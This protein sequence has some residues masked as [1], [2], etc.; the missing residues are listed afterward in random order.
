MTEAPVL[1]P[2]SNH[3]AMLWRSLEKKVKGYGW[4]TLTGTLLAS[5][6]LAHPRLLGR[7]RFIV[8][9]SRRQIRAFHLIE[10]PVIAYL[11]FVSYYALRRVDRAKA[12]RFSV[13]VDT[14]NT[15]ALAFFAFESA[16][17]IA[18]FPHCV[19]QGD[20]RDLTRGALLSLVAAGVG[21]RVQLALNDYF[22]PALD[23]RFAHPQTEEELIQLVKRARA[24]GAQL[25]VRG[26]THC[27]HPAIFTDEG[28]QHINVQLDRY[29]RILEWNETEDGQRMRVTVQ[30]GCHL[31]V[32]PGDPLSNKENSLLYQLEEKGWALPDL[33]GI[34]HQTVG[35]FLS[36]GSMGGTTRHDLGRAIVG[37]RLI[38]GTGK[39]HD[40]APNPDDPDDQAHNPF[41][42]A[43]VSLGLLGV[44]STVTFE[45][46]PRYDLVG[47]QIVRRTEKLDELQLFES[48]EKGLQHFFEED[49]DTYARLLW[50]PQKGVDKVELWRARRDYVAESKTR[51]PGLNRRPFVQVPRILQFLVNTFYNFIAHDDPPYM[52][53]TQRLV[54]LV[55]NAYLREGETKEFRGPWHEILPMDNGVDDKLMPT[56][57]TELFIPIERSAEVMS[58]LRDFFEQDIGDM[59][60][61]GPYAFEIY[62]GHESVFW[63][64]P[65]HGRHSIRVDVFWFRTDKGNR[66][67]F[68]ARFWELLQPF[69][70]RLHWG[71]FLP[72]AESAVGPEYLRQQYPMWDAFMAVRQKMDPEGVFL[73]SYWKRHLGLGGG[74]KAQEKRKQ[75]AEV[76]RVV[77]V[78]PLGG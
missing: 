50:W 31:G 51:R 37:I 10:A 19:P 63:L 24:L 23:P 32:D 8:R 13:L 65:S 61:T 18:S 56:D 52:P 25:R 33:G 76:G 7:R 60:L 67:Q 66:Q 1:R 54:R 53:L 22:H 30:A 5:V 27:V 3:E 47:R 38:D 35:G 40:L 77:R 29:T 64:S 17:L 26:S 28:E 36:T 11:G 39:V 73:S 43:G 41:Y 16:S 72:E 42:A 58:K 15:V 14:A 70:F 59:K 21:L 68:Y 49:G 2:S 74:S 44:I 46:E 55:L 6:F 4:I 20:R 9:K 48:G 69:D 71:K 34:T 62:A 57:F 12:R 78:H 45:C 75:G